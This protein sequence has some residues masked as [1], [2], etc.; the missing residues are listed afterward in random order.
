MDRNTIII[1][2]SI[3]AIVAVI[4]VMRRPGTTHEEFSGGFSPSARLA[5]QNIGP[6]YNKESY[7]ASCS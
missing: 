7:C 4:Y 1:L 2:L 6:A 3:V 5:I